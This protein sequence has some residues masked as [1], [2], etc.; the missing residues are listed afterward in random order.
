MHPESGGPALPIAVT[1][2]TNRIAERS[3]K[4]FLKGQGATALPS[5]PA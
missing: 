1:R 4:T 3:S 2:N 5:S